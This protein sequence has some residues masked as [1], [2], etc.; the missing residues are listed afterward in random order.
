MSGATPPTLYSGNIH[1]QTSPAGGLTFMSGSTATVETT[2]I[3]LTPYS[4]TSS[5]SEP[6]SGSRGG[7]GAQSGWIHHAVAAGARPGANT[8][9]HQWFSCS[10]ST[11]GH[12]A[13]MLNGVMSGP[14]AFKFDT[15][16]AGARRRAVT[17]ACTTSTT[18]PLPAHPRAVQDDFETGNAG[19]WTTTSGTSSRCSAALALAAAARACSAEKRLGRGGGLVQAVHLDPQSITRWAP[20]LPGNDRWGVCLPSHNA[21]TTT[22]ARCV[23]RTPAARRWSTAF[24]HVGSAA[25]PV[26]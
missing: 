20:M 10:I 21:I 19:A 3:A 7:Y 2:C 11:C 18:G 6:L 23:P 12:S 1:G 9:P 13:P 4:G 15:V 5:A 22:T 14:Y 16:V 26:S 17:I 25:L 8:E 24:C